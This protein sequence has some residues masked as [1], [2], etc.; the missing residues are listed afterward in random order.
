M[1]TH[2]PNA[3]VHATAGA[4][5]PAGRPSHSPAPAGST[6]FE[7]ALCA[8]MVAVTIAVCTLSAGYA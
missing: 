4:S 2:T 1:H 3:P 7:L 5:D 8:W 6:L